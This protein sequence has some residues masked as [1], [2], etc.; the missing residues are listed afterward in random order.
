M[1]VGDSS[2]E[3]HGIINTFFSSA[4]P[5]EFLIERMTNTIHHS[6]GQHH[7]ND[8]KGRTDN[9]AYELAILGVVVHAKYCRK[10]VGYTGKDGG[11]SVPE[12]YE[13]S[14]HG[15]RFHLFSSSSKA[16]LAMFAYRLRRSDSDAGT[17]QQPFI[18]AVFHF[19]RRPKRFIRVLLSFCIEARVPSLL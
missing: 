5:R 11:E 19:A 3:F 8:S 1:E 16:S 15:C 12:Q 10:P 13:S 14:F 6:C 17:A 9:T 4:L 2:G 7:H 18:S